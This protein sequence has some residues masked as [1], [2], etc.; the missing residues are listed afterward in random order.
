[1]Y[2]R[3][4]CAS[5]GFV[6]AYEQSKYEAE[7]LVRASDLPWLVLRSST[8]VCDDITG[9]V[10]QLNAVH[11]ALRVF[12]NGMAA[13]MPGTEDTPVD[14][15]TTAHVAQGVAE[16][17]MGRGQIGGTYHLCA[18]SG[19]LPL[20]QLLDGA[21]QVWARD[22]DWLRRGISRPALTDLDTYRL[23]EQSVEE[24]SLIHI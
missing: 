14:L 15:V 6:N 1:M 17:G 10:T 16:L 12:H 22:R 19:A 3:Q 2:K 18:G 23:F 11:R 7:L 24:L 21:Y 13:L 9:A 4:L 5:H 8:I 20:G